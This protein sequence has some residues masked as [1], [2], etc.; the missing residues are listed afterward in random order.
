MRKRVT[1]LLLA[2]VI[3]SS[4]FPAGIAVSAEAY[5]GG[6]CPHHTQHDENCGYI[7]AGEGAPCT[8]EHTVDCYE[9]AEDCIHVHDESCYSDGLLPSDG[10]DKK[11]EEIEP[12]L[13]SK[14]EFEYE[15]EEEYIKEENK[16]KEADGE[17]GLAE[18]YDTA[19]ENK[20][21]DACTHVCTVESA[22]LILVLN[23]AHEHDGECGYE[24]ANGGHP[25][26]FMCEICSRTITGWEWADEYEV[27]RPA[28]NYGFDDIYWVMEVPGFGE[29][30][31]DDRQVVLGEMLPS[32]V[33]AELKTGEVL[34]LDVTWSKDRNRHGGIIYTASLPEGYTLDKY[35]PEPAVLVRGVDAVTYDDYESDQ[36]NE[37]ME[38]GNPFDNA[39]HFFVRHWHTSNNSS[40]KIQGSEVKTSGDRYFTVLEGYIVPKEGEFGEDDDKF[41]FYLVYQGSVTDA[42]GTQHSKGELMEL[43]PDF[44][45]DSD[46]IET[47]NPKEGSITLKSNSADGRYNNEAE[48]FVGFSVSSGH[49]AVTYGKEEP[50]PS[51]DTGSN[52]TLKITYDKYIYLVKAHAFYLRGGK[53]VE[54]NS[55]V[56]DGLKEDGDPEVDSVWVYVYTEE[57]ANAIA[58]ATEGA[59]VPSKKKDANNNNIKY[60]KKG[61]EK[62]LPDNCKDSKT[63]KPNSYVELKKFY[64]TT[65]GLHTDKTATAKDDGRTFDVELEAWYTEKVPP[66]IGL[67]LDAS[68][69]MVAAVDEPERIQL[70]D[71]QINDLKI[72]KVEQGID[73]NSWNDYFLTDEV[74]GQ[75]LNKRYTDNS[76]LSVNAY[77]YYVNS[78]NGYDPIGYWEGVVEQ[79]TGKDFVFEKNTQT[80][81]VRGWPNAHSDLHM[82]NNGGLH[83]SGQDGNNAQSATGIVLDAVPKGKNFTISF[84][85]VTSASGDPSVGNRKIAELLYIGPMSG[86]TANGG[87]YRLFRDMGGSSGRLRGNQNPDRTGWV[88]DIDGV[89]GKTATRRVTLVFSN[90]TVT[91]YI[92]GSVGTSARSCKLSEDIRIII[93]GIGDSYTGAPIYIDDL[94][95]FNTALSA[96]QVADVENLKSDLI[97]WYEFAN[98][99]NPDPNDKSGNNNGNGSRYW[100]YNSIYDKG[101]GDT[102]PEHYASKLTEQ[103]NI[104]NS[105]STVPTLAKTLDRKLLGAINLSGNYTNNGQKVAAASGLVDAG[106][107]FITHAG[108]FSD[109]YVSAETGKRLTGITTAGL[110]INDDIDGKGSQAEYTTAAN[111]PI[112]FYIDSEGYLRCFF[113]TSGI[114]NADNTNCSY[115]YDLEDMQYT[116]A[117]ALQRALGVFVTQL[118]EK[119][120]G[121]RVSAVRF[122]S[123]DIANANLNQ[124]VIQNWT[125][126]ASE[127]AIMLSLR[128]GNGG[129][130]DSVDGQYNYGLTGATSTWRGFRAYLDYLDKDIGRFDGAPN[131][132]NDIPKYIILFTDGGDTDYKNENGKITNP[133]LQYADQ[134]KKKGYTIFTV[135]LDGAG[136]KDSDQT[137][138]DAFLPTV[139]GDKNT[140]AANVNDYMFSLS[141]GR[142]EYPEKLAQ[143]RYGKAYGSLD[144]G[145]KSAIDAEIGNMTDTDILTNIF[146]DEILGNILVDKEYYTIKDYIDPRFDLVAGVGQEVDAVSSATVVLPSVDATYTSKDKTVLYNIRLRS[147]GKV[148]LEAPNGNIY[149]MDLTY[150]SKEGPDIE[151][152]N[153]KGEYL[154]TE[155][156]VITDNSKNKVPLVVQPV[157]D[158]DGKYYLRLTLPSSGY[159]AEHPRLYWDSGKQMYYLEWK[160]QTIPGCPEGADEL[161][162]WHSSFTLHA[163][164]DFL[165]GNDVL[166]NGNE[167]NMNWVYYDG[168][169]IS[170]MNKSSGTDYSQTEYDENDP[171][172]ITRYPS[173][174]FPRTTVNVKL[175]PLA[176]GESEERIYLGEVVDP[177][178]IINKLGKTVI[179]N[180][181]WA[182]YLVRYAKIYINE[183]KAAGDESF[184]DVNPDKL[185]A[186]ELMRNML[187]A[188]ADNPSGWGL[189]L[190]YFYLPNVMDENGILLDKPTNQPG[191]EDRHQ[192]D[193]LGILHYRWERLDPATGKVIGVGGYTTGDGSGDD[194]LYGDGGEEITNGPYKGKPY[195]ALD[196]RR[197]EYRL[198][199]SY[200][201]Y[202]DPSDDFWEELDEWNK[203]NPD[204]AAVGKTPIQTV[205]DE[206]WELLGAEATTGSDGKTVLGGLSARVQSATTISDMGDISAYLNRKPKEGDETKPKQGLIDEKLGDAN[207]P[208]SI[209]YTGTFSTLLEDVRD[210][211]YE[212]TTTIKIRTSVDG[213]EIIESVPINGGLNGLLTELDKEIKNPT[214]NSQTRRIYMETALFDLRNN[215]DNLISQMSNYIDYLRWCYGYGETVTVD[216][217]G[218]K[219]E[220]WKWLPNNDKLN[221]RIDKNHELVSDVDRTIDVTDGN[222][223]KTHEK[224]ENTEEIKGPNGIPDY[225]YAYWEPKDAEGDVQLN[226]TAVGMHTTRVV[227]GELAFELELKVDDLLAMFEDGGD[228]EGLDSVPYMMKLSRAYTAQLEGSKLS[229]D[230]WKPEIKPLE[231]NVRH[232]DLE[233]LL[234]AV[235]AKTVGSQ[236]AD[237]ET[238]EPGTEPEEPEKPENKDED[239]KVG[240][241]GL[242]TLYYKSTY[243]VDDPANPGKTKEVI[244]YR[245]PRAV[246]DTR[247][248]LVTYYSDPTV[249][250]PD[251][252]ASE[253]YEYLASNN[254][255]ARLLP[256]GTYTME[257]MTKENKQYWKAFEIDLAYAEK[258][259]YEFDSWHFTR[260]TNE[261]EPNNSVDSIYFPRSGRSQT[262]GLGQLKAPEKNRKNPEDTTGE[263]KKPGDYV[264]F[265]L[266]THVY[267][268]NDY[269]SATGIPQYTDDREG[270][271]KVKVR[272]PL[273]F[274][275]TGG[276]MSIGWY[277]LL[278]PLVM[279]LAIC[280][281]LIMR[282]EKEEQMSGSS[283]QS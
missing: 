44:V 138:A 256:I 126:S 75:I 129:A 25:C 194:N 261:G 110:K 98:S 70:T 67:I 122:S 173:K 73:P 11:P 204:I 51:D 66:Q 163:K 18:V 115:V 227:R 263:L 139:A 104:T 135:L 13:E 43:G 91:S 209:T 45:Y 248:Y 89:F 63:D 207:F 5:N 162:V 265:E 228:W 210:A 214:D 95:V 65:R 158:G 200:W 96:E 249:F 177:V 234:A 212:N 76:A 152:T 16:A 50:K 222:G 217:N 17:A 275:E 172:K 150:G 143:K 197:I 86:S 179:G 218:K 12:A 277:L 9:L 220:E 237:P 41:D 136:F 231:I 267:T 119:S 198:V 208:T 276:G 88:T 39:L 147:N 141:K 26:E 22:C 83:T 125:N 38:Q 165:G 221:M 182:D 274:P 56:V 252:E 130:T 269:Y 21:A 137:T 224:V 253:G 166:T 195:E 250:D 233:R 283:Q 242:I 79:W 94:Y 268:G 140:S 196:T 243:T 271:A 2:M 82:S 71:E 28:G 144:Q 153:S 203:H 155:G 57:G 235:P 62:N 46:Y 202:P 154:N 229:G 87:Y 272:L 3:F 225:Q 42:D 34:E 107:Y 99:G 15:Y 255:Y 7:P 211:L 215:I 29:L 30:D 171:N 93:N 74:L 181:Y 100:L 206:M 188:L 259:N 149:K 109:Y 142:A 280:F 279:I 191:K 185:S 169:A 151:I 186:E 68:G 175:L 266:G 37:S 133:T 84:N 174:G 281:I 80:D 167:A 146:A 131:D 123:S 108:A 199:V 14:L 118:R 190:P 160:N 205:L 35:A 159:D 64:S 247:T 187:Q 244:E 282:I 4:I 230:A 105:S 161:L 232:D 19:A 72:N 273:M 69:S 236:T 201:P 157:E 245:Y 78:A 8:H 90:G 81:V 58:D 24:A 1:S 54:G 53:L 251:Y 189:D 23:C 246:L 111:T 156:E 260:T 168:P 97:G 113:S 164:N 31:E 101:S 180:Y 117:E 121:S 264:V 223:K 278:I 92:D 134:L 10:E 61:D 254:A 240:E 103:L 145:Q 77:S 6:L 55:D 102:A 176:I 124:L 60:V 32:A 192:S 258:K 112:R 48:R 47:W 20:E 183:R 49:G 219:T 85:L 59:F 238:E 257:P 216:N 148:E 241:D 184:K 114:S 36:A 106:W 40:G 116:R 193:Q 262:Y 178:S 226:K 213:K 52:E 127:S 239:L 120:P 27:L 170:N 33:S 132:P 270:M 128:R